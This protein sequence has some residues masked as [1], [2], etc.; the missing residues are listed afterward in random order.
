MGCGGSAAA[1]PTEGEASPGVDRRRSAHVLPESTGVL[2][3]A[4][5]AQAISDHFKDC[6]VD[7]SPVELEC[8]TPLYS[9]LND[10]LEKH[11]DDAQRLRHTQNIVKKCEAAGCLKANA[12]TMIKCNACGSTLPETEGTSTN[13]FTS[14]IYGIGPF[15]ISIRHASPDVMVLDDMMQVTPCHFDAIPTD[16]YIQDWRWLLNRPEDALLLIEKLKS[17]SETAMSSF[18]NNQAYMQ[19]FINTDAH[20]L[21]LQ[22][23]TEH[24]AAGFN[25]PPSQYQLHL[26][27][28][29]PP[30]TPFQYQMLIEGKGF[31]K[32]RFFPFKYVRSVLECSVKNG[33]A[34]A[35]KVDS[36]TGIDTIMQH[37]DKLGVSYDEIYTEF[38]GNIVDSHKKLANWQPEDFALRSKGEE[39]FQANSDTEQGIY[40]N[41]I[42]AEQGTLQDALRS[43]KKVI[44]NYGRP[45][46]AESAKPSGAFYKHAR[47]EAL[48]D[49]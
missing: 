46:Q 26:Q 34:N 24:V 40:K 10:F 27:Y 28:M 1:Q 8:Q 6:Y 42:P 45:Y 47:T 29:L 41:P 48:A 9:G 37:F 38:Y 7:L 13:I 23:V 11:P 35:I 4:T 22:D 15:K 18:W 17:R 31:V 3:G 14:F 21:S 32:G 20:G 49:W 30:F 16:H 36:Q 33:G 44:E 2:G 19:K 43:D 12:R 39:M 25:F 5:F